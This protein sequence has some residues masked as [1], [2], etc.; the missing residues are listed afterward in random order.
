[1]DFIKALTAVILTL[2]V[3]VTTSAAGA[4][5]FDGKSI[6][7]GDDAWLC[8]PG[9][10]DTCTMDQTATVISADGKLTKEAFKPDPDAP[11]DCFYIYPTVSKQP[12]GNSDLAI[13]PEEKNAVLQQFARFGAKCRLFAPMYRQVTV[14]ALISLGS[15][16]PIAVDRDLAYRDVAAAWNDYLA[17]DN[18]ERGVILIGHSQGSSVLKSLIQNEIDGKPL[19]NRII[20][21]LLMGPGGTGLS[22]PN[23]SDVGGA[24][25]HIPVCHSSSQIGCVIA[26]NSFRSEAPP[27][28]G[29]RF[30]KAAEGMH[31]VCANPAALGGGSGEL[32]AYLSTSNIFLAGSGPP[33]AWTN[34]PQAIDTP[35]V[36]VPGLLSA[37]CV[38]NE[39]GTYLAITIQ[40]TQGGNRTSTISGDVVINGKVLPDWGL[41]LIDANLTMG[42]LVAIVGEQSKAYSAKAAKKHD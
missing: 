19:Q 4:S 34:P 27:P 11:V 38:T 7:S 35:Y 3:G 24:F 13:E 32:D 1:M 39:H 23:G 5:E 25:Q 30:V 42:N 2:A 16:N 36:K 9:R 37:E 22:V 41:H 14:P 20:S 33:T 6:Y 10:Q 18:H 21:V 12:T 17:R 28:A 29:S 40:S 26:F 15:S 8:R 31:A